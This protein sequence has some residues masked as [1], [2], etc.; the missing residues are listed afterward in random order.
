[1]L[2]RYYLPLRHDEVTKTVLNSHL[3]KFC[4][5]KQITVTSDPEYIF[6]EHPQE[7]WWDI[8]TKTASKILHNKPDLVIWNKETKLCTIIEFSCPLDTNIGRKVS[9]KLEAYGS[10]V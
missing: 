6:K 7:Y 4:P 1:M 3:K 2:A 5:D 9:E 8:L 10:L